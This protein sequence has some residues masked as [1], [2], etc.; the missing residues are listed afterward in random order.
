MFCVVGPILRQLLAGV[1]LQ[2]IPKGAYSALQIGRRLGPFAAPS[3]IA[4]RIAQVV[5]R[6]RPIPRQLLPD[7]HLECIPIGVDGLL[8]IGHRMRSF[9]A[10]GQIAKRN[11]EVVLRRGPILRQLL[12]GANLECIPI[13]PDSL[14]QIGRAPAVLRYAQP[15][16]PAQYPGCSA[17]PPNPAEV[18]H[19]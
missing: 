15:D 5:L 17:S 14:L 6:R 1:H 2:C 10:S 12:T 3:Q 19:G 9:A 7:A 13:G 18:A 16:R 11:A 4:Q 8:E